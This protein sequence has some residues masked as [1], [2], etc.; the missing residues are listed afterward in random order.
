M[1]ENGEL[2]NGDE[3]DSDEMLE[4]KDASSRIDGNRR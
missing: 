3:S 4:L 2:V 1:H